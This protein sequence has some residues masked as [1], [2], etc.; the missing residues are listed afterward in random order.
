M[1]THYTD[2]DCVGLVKKKK[3]GKKK[4]RKTKKKY[5]KK[6]IKKQRE[7]ERKKKLREKKTDYEVQVFNSVYWCSLNGVW[8]LRKYRQL[9][10]T[11]LF[12]TMYVTVRF[13]GEIIVPMFTVSG[14]RSLIIASD[15]EKP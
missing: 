3:R 12:A 10:V 13:G 7:T 5:I 1:W 15:P 9:V 4:G 11:E 2:H 14:R 8:G 6:Y